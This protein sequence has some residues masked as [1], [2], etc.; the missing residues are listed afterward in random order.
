M[1]REMVC[2]SIQ[3]QAANGVALARLFERFGCRIMERRH[4]QLLVG[5]PE[6]SNEREAA[7]EAR[8][9]LSMRPPNGGRLRPAA[10]TISL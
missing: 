3:T 7:A 4:D 9:Y 1:S 10:A 2:L 6:A 5:F 8:L